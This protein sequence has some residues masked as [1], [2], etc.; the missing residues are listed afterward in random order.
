MGCAGGGGT[1]V[2]RVR[3]NGCTGCGETDVQG[4]G[5]RVCKVRGRRIESAR[6]RCLLLPSSSSVSFSPLF[7]PRP[8]SA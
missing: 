4:E 1:W 6:A 5:N 8:S 7:L 3:G 2:C